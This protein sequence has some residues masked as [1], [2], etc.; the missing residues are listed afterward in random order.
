MSSENEYNNYYD[1]TRK[2][3]TELLLDSK[4]D[5]LNVFDFLEIEHKNV[6]DEI[7][8][9]ILS[10]SLNSTNF[11]ETE[12]C[13]KFIINNFDDFPE[14]ITNIFFKNYNQNTYSN[15]NY[16]LKTEYFNLPKKTRINILIKCVKEMRFN[17]FV[18]YAIENDFD[19]LPENIINGFFSIPDYVKHGVGGITLLWIKPLKQNFDKLSEIRRNDLINKIINY[20]YHI[21]YFHIEDFLST[22]LENYEK[23]PKEAQNHVYNLARKIDYRFQTKFK[24]YFLKLPNLVR[25]EIL[26]ILIGNENSFRTAIEIICEYYYD[27]SQ[28]IQQLLFKYA[29]QNN[30]LRLHEIANNIILNYEQLPE[31]AKEL[32]FKL[33]E[34]DLTAWY[35]TSEIVANY[36]KFPE[37]AKS[38]LFNL[39]EKNYDIMEPVKQHFESLPKNWRE[40][41]ID[42]LKDKPQSIPNIIS[43]IAKNFDNLPE[44]IQDLFLIYAKND[45]NYKL[46]V[47]SIIK[48]Y[49]AL[50]EKIKGLLITFVDKVNI[51]DLTLSLRWDLEKPQNEALPVEVRD[52]L[53]QNLLNREFSPD[54]DNF[55]EYYEFGQFVDFLSDEETIVPQEIK[56]KFNEKYE[57]LKY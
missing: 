38:L 6:P 13:L 21:E 8:A 23:L 28:S 57:N 2:I 4:I 11:K 37:S 36:T 44:S 51:S 5:R 54:E 30:N 18:S 50:P 24:E 43:I 47:E 22:L 12:K 55:D 33:L 27:L 17:D 9:Q 3:K 39:V 29:E 7:L 31:I 19:N 42:R 48:N 25:E 40:Y 56:D 16:I 10:N 15:S 20:K 14:N 1:E 41:F 46:I 34:K 35:T 53:F 32:L 49:N 26:L 52:K 45:E